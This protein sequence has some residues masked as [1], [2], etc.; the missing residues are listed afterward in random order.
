MWLV[1]GLVWAWVAVS[2]SQEISPI[3]FLE[4]RDAGAP[5]VFGQVACAQWPVQE[6]SR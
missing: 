5:F 2:L 4:S 3:A 6:H 1:A